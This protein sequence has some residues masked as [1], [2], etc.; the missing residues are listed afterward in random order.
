MVLGLKPG[1]RIR[2]YDLVKLIGERIP[3]AAK[4]CAYETTTSPEWND[5]GSAFSGRYERGLKILLE[6]M[7]IGE[8]K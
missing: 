7:G 4:I 2:A 6:S 5:C 3:K 8:G 1:D